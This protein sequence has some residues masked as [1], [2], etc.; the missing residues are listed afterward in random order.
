M[1]KLYHLILLVSIL[2][3]SCA[4][5][6]KTDIP[7]ISEKKEVE[8]PEMALKLIVDSIVDTCSTCQN[9]YRRQAI[10]ILNREFMPSRIIS[11]IYACPFTRIKECGSYEFLLSCYKE[12]KSYTPPGETAAK[13]FPLII[14]KIHTIKD[15]MIGISKTDYTDEKNAYILKSITPG[16]VFGARIEILNFPYGDGPAFNIIEEKNQVVVHCKILDMLK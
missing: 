9:K 4:Q 6:Q 10:N 11:S 2:S 13:L 1:K 15:H 7:V 5:S 8:V 14:F 3:V 12:R 16:S